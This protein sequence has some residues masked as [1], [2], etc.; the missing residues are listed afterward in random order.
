MTE[1]ALGLSTIVRHDF[2]QH[3]E[4]QPQQL[5]VRQGLSAP[6]LA[7]EQIPLIM[8][9]IVAQLVQILLLKEFTVS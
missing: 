3:L 5:V 2:L 7:A 8:N 6:R 1:A 9:F 4:Y